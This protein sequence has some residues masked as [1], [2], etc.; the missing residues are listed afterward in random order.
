MAKKKEVQEPAETPKPKKRKSYSKRATQA[1]RKMSRNRGIEP[2]GRKKAMN[3]ENCKLTP[4]LAKQMELLIRQGNFIK[5]AAQVCGIDANTFSV[6]MRR[7]NTAIATNNKLP[8]EQKFANF[9][10]RMRR[11]EAQAEEAVNHAG[12]VDHKHSGVVEL[13]LSKFTLEQKKFFLDVLEGKKTFDEMPTAWAG[14]LENKLVL[15]PP[16]ES[17]TVADEHQAE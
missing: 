7:G 8:E 14:L 9:V 3:N 17:E 11:A 16:Q 13:D 5:T 15:L 1:R 6:W 10:H 2:G 4:K 12:E